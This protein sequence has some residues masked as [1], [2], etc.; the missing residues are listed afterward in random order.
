M[1]VKNKIV[2]YFFNNFDFLIRVMYCRFSWINK[3]LFWRFYASDFMALD[4][5]FERRY[6]L[7]TNNNLNVIENKIVLELGPGNSYINAYN[8]LM[9]GAKKIILVDKFS[10]QTKTKKQKRFYYDEI[11]YIKRK[12]KANDLFFL[13]ED[14]SINKKYIET[15]IGDASTIQLKDQVDFIFSVSVLEHIKEVRNFIQNLTKWLKPDGYIYH[16]ID[17]RDHYNF[18][19]PFLFYKYSDNIWNSLLTREGVSYTNRVRYNNFKDIFKNCNLSTVYERKEEHRLL[20]K[21]I[22]N[23]FMGRNDLT[24]VQLE[25]ILK[26]RNNNECN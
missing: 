4:R 9:R 11:S 24:I 22:D 20:P 2:S 12:Y 6:T 7:L 19:Q 17:L 13:N 15:H 10:R 21:K 1:K 18:N 16:F 14:D 26:K 3:L 23:Q 25:I 5:G 8:F